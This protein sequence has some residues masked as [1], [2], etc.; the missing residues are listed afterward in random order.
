MHVSPQLLEYS[1][2]Q[3]YLHNDEQIS[4]SV[5]HKHTLHTIQIVLWRLG[6]G[7]VAKWTCSVSCHG[8]HLEAVLAA[9]L[10]TCGDTDRDGGGSAVC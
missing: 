3:L 5:T 2:Q 10:Q 8:C 1:G 4:L 9:F 6:S 7:P